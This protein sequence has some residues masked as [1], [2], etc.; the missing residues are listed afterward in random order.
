V[1]SPT[2]PRNPKL[3]LE[4]LQGRI[5]EFV[6]KLN[7][8][9]NTNPTAPDKVALL[10]YIV[11]V[12]EDYFR[13]SNQNNIRNTVTDQLL[14]IALFR[15]LNIIKTLGESPEKISPYKTLIADSLQKTES[16]LG[17][18]IPAQ[19]EK[20]KSSVEL[21]KKILP[22]L[23]EPALSNNVQPNPKIAASAP[24][25][26]ASPDVQPLAA[27]PTLVPGLSAKEPLNTT[28]APTASPADLIEASKTHA[29]GQSDN[30][31]PSAPPQE[32]VQPSTGSLGSE[33]SA[34]KESLSSDASTKSTAN[35]PLKRATA[36][37]ADRP[38]TDLPS[39][40]NKDEA[41]VTRGPLLTEKENVRNAIQ[42]PKLADKSALSAVDKGLVKNPSANILDARVPINNK[43][44]AIEKTKGRIKGASEKKFAQQ[45][46]SN[47]TEKP[48]LLKRIGGF[49][50]R[51]K[52]KI[53]T[54][55]LIAV[56]LVTSAFTFG[57]TAIAGA[58]VL[59]AS[60]LGQMAA[61]GFSSLSAYIIAAGG[62]ALLGLGVTLVS[63]AVKV[64]N[65][66]KGKEQIERIPQSTSPGKSSSPKINQQEALTASQALRRRSEQARKD[67][68]DIAKPTPN[69]MLNQYNT[70]SSSAAFIKTVSERDKKIIKNVVLDHQAKGQGYKYQDDKN[71]FSIIGPNPVSIISEAQTRGATVLSYTLSAKTPLEAL[72]I[73]EVNERALA[74]Q[75]QKSYVNVTKV[76]ISGKH[77]DS[78]EAF[79]KA[80]GPARQ[81][82]SNHPNIP[83]GNNRG[84]KI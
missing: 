40:L 29:F 11:N 12:A 43:Q 13:Y 50:G 14:E 26:L 9:E 6:E 76:K 59:N 42:K 16:L 67:F 39:Y 74:Q 23:T 81:S 21:V 38:N 19:G 28:L 72:R 63:D 83:N 73:I 10:G 4:S 80:H 31:Q 48:S 15:S 70:A 56:V 45:Y 1:P 78:V 41:R 35:E 5:L 7:S 30:F 3:Q 66:L 46:P 49:F 2:P 17:N 69:L 8:Y 82:P 57:G 65:K 24:V 52:K 18:F 71:G 22:P 32:L 75:G 79:M 44:Q 62:A 64:K 77:Y 58:I 37:S 47:K 55:A 68:E 61:A 25:T 54:A 60:F 27:A 84:S 20:I 51:H 34:T 53:L 33:K 36:Y